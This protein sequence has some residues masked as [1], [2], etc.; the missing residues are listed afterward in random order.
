MKSKTRLTND[1]VVVGAIYLDFNLLGQMPLAF[2]V[3]RDHEVIGSDYKVAAGGSA[4]VFAKALKSLGLKTALLAQAGVDPAGRILS[5]EISKDKVKVKLLVKGKV[6]TNISANVSGDHNDSLTITAG[7]ANQRLDAKKVLSQAKRLLAG[8][9]VFYIG[10]Y[11]KMSQLAKAYLALAK[12]CQKRKI[13]VVLDHGTVHA[14]VSRADLRNLYRL[15]QYVNY[16]LPNQEEFL[17]AMQAKNLRQAFQRSQ[18]FSKPTIV[19]KLGRQGAVLF[20]KHKVVNVQA[21]RVPI[22]HTVGAGDSFNAGFIYGILNKLPIH[23]ALRVGNAVA[24]LRISQ[25]RLPTA[26]DIKKFLAKKINT[27]DY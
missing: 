14:K 11:F 10:G 3:H 1:V 12:F 5:Q 21:F 13:L 24:A 19:V 2:N 18:K 25:P 8:A 4:Y 26:R 20:E 7:N 17:R 27:F 6:Q 15:L 16:Y 22:M 9:R 23:K